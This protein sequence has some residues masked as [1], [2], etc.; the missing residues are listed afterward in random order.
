MQMGRIR[1]MVL[2]AVLATIA[3]SGVRAGD[4][5]RELQRRDT[6]PTGGGANSAYAKECGA[7]H[8]AF[9]PQLLPRRS[10]T[11]IMDTL[12]G[13]FGENASLDEPTRA[14][15]LAYLVANSAETGGSKKSRKMLSSIGSG[16]TPLR[17][18]EIPYFKREHDEIRPEVFKRKSIVSPA[19]CAACHP[20]AEQG[21]FD[22]HRVRIPKD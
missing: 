13:H 20:A 14:N 19:N 15:I 1:M 12:A 8:L 4:D 5:G 2:V 21:D 3:A 16:E 9:P 11:K 17:I 6:A 10:W 18:T 22:E 7:C